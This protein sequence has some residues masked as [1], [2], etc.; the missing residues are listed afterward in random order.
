MGLVLFGGLKVAPYDV[1]AISPLKLDRT[2]QGSVPL[3]AQRALG[4]QMKERSSVQD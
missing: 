1:F 3:A 4:K 2:H